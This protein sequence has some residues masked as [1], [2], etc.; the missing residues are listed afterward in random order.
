[1]WVT[2]DNGSTWWGRPGANSAE[3]RRNVWAGATVSA[4]RPGM[5]GAAVRQLG[6]GEGEGVGGD[7]VVVGGAVERRRGAR[8]RCGVADG[9]RPVVVRGVRVGAGGVPLGWV[10]VFG[11]RVGRRA[12]R[13][14]G[15]E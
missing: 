10:C 4:D 14:C 5:G 2:P 3:E 13:H 11:G 8:R 9:A 15:V 12:P 1:M 6:G 7:G